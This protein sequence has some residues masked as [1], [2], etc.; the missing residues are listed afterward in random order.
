MRATCSA[1]GAVRTESHAARKSGIT[2]TW[3]MVPPPDG[4]GAC[5]HAA[6]R[7]SSIAAGTPVRT[8]Q[9]SLLMRR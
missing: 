9:G 2:F 6:P 7:K 4:P 3:A 8:L 5:A 1:R